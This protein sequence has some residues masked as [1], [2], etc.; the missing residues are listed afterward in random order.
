M[1]PPPHHNGKYK[2]TKVNISRPG[3]GTTDMNTNTHRLTH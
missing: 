3:L 1:R 2:T